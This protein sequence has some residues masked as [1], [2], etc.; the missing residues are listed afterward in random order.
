MNFII[1]LSKSQGLIIRETYNVI[2]MIIN[3][4]TKY[5]YIVSFKKIYTIEL[6]KYIIL[7][8]LIRY[9]EILKEIISNKD[10]RFILNY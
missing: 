8:K 1:K 6:L 3:R 9:H 4:L 7:N 10:K 2:L 5:L